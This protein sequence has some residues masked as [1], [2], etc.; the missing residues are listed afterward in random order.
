MATIIPV[1]LAY[2]LGSV[3][4]SLLIGRLRGGVDIRT[5]GSGNAGGTNALRT[6]GPAF[7][8]A[9]LV[10][11]LAK[12]WVAVA[13]LPMLR[14][15]AAAAVAAGAAAAQGAPEWVPA[16]CGVAAIVGHVYPV[17]HGFR[18]G[19]G[20]ATL[21]GTLAGLAPLSIVGVLLVW[22]VMMLVFGFV[23]LASIVAAAS[24]PAVLWFID[25]RPLATLAV[26]GMFVALLV[27]YTHRGNLARMRAGTEPRA[28]RLWLL[29]RLRGARRSS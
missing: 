23:G 28:R 24:L 9:V 1:L 12:G 15:P 29:G 7:A 10:I 22:L 6:Q 20:V 26:F 16:A 13:L 2:L 14:W 21:I 4:G 17:F 11:D 3:N 18:G 5:Q 19:K 27:L 8:A 25:A